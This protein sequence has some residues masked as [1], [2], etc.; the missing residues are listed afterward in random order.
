MAMATELSNDCRCALSKKYRS[1]M[2]DEW[3]AGLM[4]TRSNKSETGRSRVLQIEVGGRQVDR[5]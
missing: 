3:I 5:T 4:A 2:R 1:E